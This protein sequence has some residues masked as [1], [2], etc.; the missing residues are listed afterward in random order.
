MNFDTFHCTPFPPL[1]VRLFLDMPGKRVRIK[2]R[3]PDLRRAAVIPGIGAVGP[4]EPQT[5]GTCRGI[6]S[7]SAVQQG[8]VQHGYRNCEV[9]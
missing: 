6:P 9:V 5:Q 1:A 8:D 2:N 7:G 4:T 3:V